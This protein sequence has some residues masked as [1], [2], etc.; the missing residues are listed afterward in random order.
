MNQKTTSA[1]I[2]K[3]VVFEIRPSINNYQP[4]AY[5]ISD[6]LKASS[7]YKPHRVSPGPLYSQTLTRTYESKYQRL[8]RMLSL[9]TYFSSKNQEPPFYYHMSKVPPKERYK[10]RYARMEPRS[11][12]LDGMRRDFNSFFPLEYLI[13][14]N[15]YFCFEVHSPATDYFLLHHHWMNDIGSNRSVRL[16][17]CSTSAKVVLTY[18]QAVS[19]RY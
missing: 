18:K 13:N 15:I 14:K 10:F 11:A 17:S 6:T 4:P 9:P 3:W 2:T 5:T 12:T 8:S 1:T 16:K 19:I 7:C